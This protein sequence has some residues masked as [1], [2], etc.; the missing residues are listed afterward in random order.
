MP[1]DN[2]S[3]S[4]PS[5]PTL[6][7]IPAFKPLKPKQIRFISGLLRHAFNVEKAARHLKCDWRIHYIW[8]HKP[9]YKQAIEYAKELIADVLESAML[10]DAIEGHKSDIVYK[11]EVTGNYREVFTSERIA[12]LKGLK[13]QYREGFSLN[14]VG[15]VALAIS[16]PGQSPRAITPD[17]SLNKLGEDIEEAKIINPSKP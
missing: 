5:I 11:G 14:N 17:N 6:K 9:E 8:L 3:I 13:P 1:P 10:G 12:L 15:P 2:S 4:F 7:R 16:Y